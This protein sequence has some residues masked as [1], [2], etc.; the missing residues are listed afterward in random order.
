MDERDEVGEEGAWH[1]RRGRTR[2]A[3]AAIPTASQMVLGRWEPVIRNDARIKPGP[4]PIN[5]CLP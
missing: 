5:L 1:R 4:V 3:R 2:T